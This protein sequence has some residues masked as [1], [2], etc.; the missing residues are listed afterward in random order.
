MT[1]IIAVSNQKGGVAKT[2][3]CVSIGACLAE[4]KRRV[5]VIDLDPQA[6]LTLSAGLDPDE[7]SPTIVDLFDENGPGQKASQ[8]VYPTLQPGM[9]LLPGDIRLSRLEQLLPEQDGYEYSLKNIL[10]QFFDHYD[11]ILVD[12]PPS[13]GALTITALTASHQA[14]IPT[15]CEYF[16]T[17]S[18]VRL[19]EIIEAVQKRTNPVLS[20]ALFI[21]MFDRRTLISQQ[22]LDQM[23]KHFQK[24]LLDTV[25]NRDTRLRECVAAGEPITVYAPRSRASQQYRQ[26][27]REILHLSEKKSRTRAYE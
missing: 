14:L 26:L 11:D 3:S 15:P 8:A 4:E 20:Y 13:L 25:I 23:R 12:C 18:L 16:A 10:Q 19:L 2:T 17:R 6:H 1:T 21:T 22:I 7:L 5:L 27:A 24:T 9:E